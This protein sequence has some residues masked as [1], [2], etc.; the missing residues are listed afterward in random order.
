MPNPYEDILDFVLLPPTD[1]SDEKS[2]AV[3]LNT[4]FNQIRARLGEKKAIQMFAVHTRTLTKK[5][6]TVWKNAGLIL[7][8]LH[9]DKRDISA[10]ARELAGEG[11]NSAN[12][13][14]AWRQQIHVALKD[15]KAIAEA[16]KVWEECYD[17]KFDDFFHPPKSPH[18][19]S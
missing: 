1:L 10:L 4:I 17:R 6:E 13:V 18:K 19:T 2:V 15:K 8:S 9:M 14:E 3:W 7:R 16:R 12:T 5:D 11:K